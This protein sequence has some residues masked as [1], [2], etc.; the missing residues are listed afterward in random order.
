MVHLSAH[1]IRQLAVAA[2]RDP[3]TI[4]NAYRGTARGVALASV[5]DAALALGLPVPPEATGLVIGEIG[6]PPTK[7]AS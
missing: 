6:A 4:V 7:I 1:Q 5:R 3:R 2:Q